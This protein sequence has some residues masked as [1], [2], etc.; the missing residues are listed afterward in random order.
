MKDVAPRLSQCLDKRQQHID[1]GQG[2]GAVHGYRLRLA[3]MWLRGQLMALQALAEYLLK[4][5]E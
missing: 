1:G 4:G 2:A 3:E 5:V